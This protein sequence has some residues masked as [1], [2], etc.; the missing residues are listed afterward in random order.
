LV[1]SLLAVF[2][3]RALGGE[4]FLG[5]DAVE[6]APRLTVRGSAGGSARVDWARDPLGPW[7]AWTNVAVSAEGMVLVDLSADPSQRFYRAVDDP[8]PVAPA[9]FVWIPPGTF[10]MGSPST[11]LW[12]KEHETQ[13][14]VVLTRGFFMGRYEVTQAEYQTLMTN[15]PS[16]FKGTNLPVESITWI[17]ATNY[18][19]RLTERERLAGRLPEG[20]E[21][22]LP[23]EAQWEYACRAGTTTATAYGSSLSSMQAN[24]DGSYPYNGGS[25]GPYLGKTAPVGSY[26]PNAW[27]LFDMHGN[28]WEFCSDWYG[29]YPTTQVQDPQGPVKGGS[30]VI[31]GGSWGNLGDGC[32]SSA[33]N[34]A[35]Q[36]YGYYFLGIRVVLVR[37]R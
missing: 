17:Q 4:V 3:A 36:G 35:L 37:V 30:R 9:G 29:P 7:T 2:L 18:C 15:N 34:W 19:A 25:V 33:R 26:A 6:E 8:T 27:G 12:R 13:H 11:E 32:R 31:R 14:E 16:T 24:F 22:R 1:L 5:L 21:Y 28:V 20:W 10:L 23:T